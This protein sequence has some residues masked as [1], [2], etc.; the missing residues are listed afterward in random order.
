MIKSQQSISDKKEKTREN[1]KIKT[2]M[3]NTVF[4]NSSKEKFLKFSND[5]TAHG[6]PFIFEKDRHALSRLFWTVCLLASTAGCIYL[7]LITINKYF[8]YNVTNKVHVYYPSSTEFPAI[9]ICNKNQFLTGQALNHVQ[10]VMKREGIADIANNTLFATLSN[11]VSTMILNLNNLRYTAAMETNVAN[12]SESLRRSYS[13]S[14]NETVLFCMFKTGECTE[15][16]FVWRYMVDFGSCW[17][18]NSGFDRHGN[19]MDIKLVNKPGQFDGLQMLLYL[20]V[21]DDERTLTKDVG[22]HIFI[23]NN[24]VLPNLYEGLSISTGHSSNVVLTKTFQDYLPS[25]YNEC[26]EELDSLDD[27]DSSIYR[28]MIQSNFTYRKRE[29]F[30]LCYQ[31]KMLDECKCYDVGLP[32]LNSDKPCLT[33]KELDCLNT[34][35]TNFYGEEVEKMCS[36]KW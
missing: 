30:F 31:E 21:P 12:V 6:I 17:A 11:S 4:R 10:N 32:S 16:D 29:C 8:E 1:V 33:K 18:F 2:K 5:T 26:F 34:L 15:N 14:F 23:H 25:P 13:N 36:L 9:T 7:V 24:T 20:G 3:A 35:Y 22:A 27:F 19:R 28:Y